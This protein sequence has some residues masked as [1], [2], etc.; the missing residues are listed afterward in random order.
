[1]CVCVC[2]WLGWARGAGACAHVCAKEHAFREGPCLG[3][4]EMTHLANKKA[5][6]T[7]AVCPPAIVSPDSCEDLRPSLLDPEGEHVH[8]P[9]SR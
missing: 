1:V 9:T 4:R 5:C 2:V 8:V 7:H 6:H 3:Y